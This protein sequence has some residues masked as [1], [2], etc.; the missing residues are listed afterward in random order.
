VLNFAF[1]GLAFETGALL[2]SAVAAIP[3]PGSSDSVRDWLA[4]SLIEN[5]GPELAA[6]EFACGW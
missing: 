6:P 4:D 2:G 3:G 5:F 1:S